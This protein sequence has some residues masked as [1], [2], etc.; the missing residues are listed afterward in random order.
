[1]RRHATEL[2]SISSRIERLYSWC[3]K[4]DPGSDE[5]SEASKSLCIL[6]AGY[7]EC[8]LRHVLSHYVAR[9]KLERRMESFA[10]QTIDKFHSVSLREI[11]ALLCKFDPAWSQALLGPNRDEQVPAA[12][13]SIGNHRNSL[14]HGRPSGVSSDQV[15]SYYLSIQRGFESLE[16]AVFGHNL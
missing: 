9:L 13:E 8:R 16:K 11:D 1:M 6:V 7:I 2:A 5:R 12:I 15:I 14:A 4:L 3:D 10:F